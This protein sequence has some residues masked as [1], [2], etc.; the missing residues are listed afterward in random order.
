MTID[1]DRHRALAR[2]KLAALVRDATG[3]SVDVAEIGAGAAVVVDGTAWVYLPGEAER[4]LG[5][6]LVWAAHHGAAAAS[7]VVDDVP[8]QVPAALAGMSSMVQVRRADERSLVEVEPVPLAPLAPMPEPP[9]AQE[10]QAAGLEV[11][12]DH[13]LWLG[14]INGLEVARMSSDGDDL[15][16]GVGAYDRGAFEALYPDSSPLDALGRVAATVAEHR[17]PGAPPHLM[18]R[19][20]R[21]RWLRAAICRRPELVGL[22]DAAPVPGVTVRPGLHETV[23]DAAVGRAGTQRVLVVTSAGIDAEV[24][25]HAAALAARDDVERVVVAL[26]EGNDHP[27]IAAALGWLDRPAETVAVAAPWA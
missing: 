24:V 5:R 10:L 12:A 21:E 13:G 27:A 26:T 25:T 3:R 9:L 1:P 19:L 8:P 16:L 2:A 20:V 6:A 22:D 15:R 23:P 17:R 7:V 18:N 4:A 14:E 11:V